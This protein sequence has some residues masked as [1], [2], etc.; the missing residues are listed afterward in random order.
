MWATARELQQL[1]DCQDWKFLKYLGICGIHQ[2][3]GNLGSSPKAWESRKFSVNFGNFP[4]PDNWK[5]K[6]PQIL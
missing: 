3:P 6:H 2:M 1:K 4:V 5:I